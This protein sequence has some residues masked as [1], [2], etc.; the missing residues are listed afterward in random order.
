MGMNE[1]RLVD[2]PTAAR[3][4]SL[5]PQTLRN[6]VSKGKVPSN[7]T[8][9]LGGKRL[10]DLVELYQWVEQVKKSR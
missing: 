4:L 7:A 8:F 1:V 9:K 10:F 5:A 3:M 2:L 6:W